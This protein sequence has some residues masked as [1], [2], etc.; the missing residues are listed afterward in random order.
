[1]KKFTSVAASIL[2]AAFCGLCTGCATDIKV[3]NNNTPAPDVFTSAEDAPIAPATDYK[4]ILNPGRVA[5]GSSFTNNKITSGATEVSGGAPYYTDN[6]YVCTVSAG[7]DLPTPTTTRSGMTFVGWRYASEGELVTVSAMPDTSKLTENLYLY[8]EWTTS[9]SGPVDPP[10]G[11]VDPPVG[12][13]D[14][15]PSK[16][17]GLYLG[18]TKL[19]A[20][21][22]N[23]G[24]SRK[25]YWL[26][27]TKVDLT[28]GQKVSLYM[29]GEKVSAY[30]EPNSSGIDMGDSSTEYDTF[31]VNLAGSFAVYLHQNDSDWS[32]QFVVTTPV[33]EVEVSIPAGAVKS[34]INFKGG[35]K[36]TIYIKNG[37][38][39]ATSFAGYKLYMWNGSTEYFGAWDDVPQMTAVMDATSYDLTADVS[40]ILR[41]GSGQTRD[42]AGM[43]I[44]GTYQI[45]FVNGA[46]NIER[47]K[48]V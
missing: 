25:E 6:A 28:V 35:G 22:L 21:T 39:Y 37:N 24:A 42:L 36:V 18:D 30:I 10:V 15:T 44:G 46:G 4:V 19:G 43:E 27:D 31:T 8:A 41:S 23:T 2:A 48:V 47:I 5:N 34:E 20:L 13:V 17:D 16:A 29:N 7:A 9:G 33:N 3:N 40:F 12:P 26:G 14:P 45:T 38:N 1:M 32:V 11:P